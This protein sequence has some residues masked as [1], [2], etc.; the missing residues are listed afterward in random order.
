VFA[1]DYPQ[2]DAQTQSNPIHPKKNPEVFPPGVLNENLSD[3]IYFIATKSLTSS[4]PDS[5]QI[6]TP[7]HDELA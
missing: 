1:L 3:W 6:C 2:Y 4:D 5:D 7:V